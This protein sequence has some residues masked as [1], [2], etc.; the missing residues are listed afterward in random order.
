MKTYQTET[1]FPVTRNWGYY[2]VLHIGKGYRVKELVINPHSKLSKQRHKYRTESWNLVKGEGYL[3]LHDQEKSHKYKLTT[4]TCIHVPIL[5]WHQGI[6]ESDE[7]CHIIE[8]WRGN[9]ENLNEDDI[10]RV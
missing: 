9:D 8:I 6:N 5:T 10:E 4:D 1:H 2:K 7:P 3:L